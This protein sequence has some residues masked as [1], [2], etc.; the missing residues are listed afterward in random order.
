MTDRADD[1]SALRRLLNHRGVVELLDLLADR[2]RTVRD[3][4]T[5]L[6]LRRP[7]VSRVLRVVAAHGLVRTE[8]PGSWDDALSI[9]TPIEL[10]ET[11]W[12]TVE[13]LSSF[14]VWESLY[15]HSDPTRDL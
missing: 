3:L 12:R 14:T 15:Q 8:G 2:P 9:T 11:G 6:G 1:L 7:G 5:A 13:L 10:T 4:R